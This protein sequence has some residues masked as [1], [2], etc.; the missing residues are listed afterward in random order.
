M[1]DDPRSY[2]YSAPRWIM[3]FGRWSRW[4]IIILALW[5][6]I[7][8][9]SYD[10]ERKQVDQEHNRISGYFWQ[11]RPVFCRTANLFHRYGWTVGVRVRAFRSSTSSE[12]V[13]RIRT[14]IRA[15]MLLMAS[16]WIHYIPSGGL[17]DTH[18]TWSLG[19]ED[20]IVPTCQRCL[21]YLRFGD[22][23]YPKVCIQA[24]YINQVI[25]QVICL[26]MAY[27]IS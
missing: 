26:R 18:S 15:T 12:T 7:R 20:R 3:D 1:I 19:F 13:F 22:P 14:T 4:L 5:L 21:T 23:S 9:S 16:Y 8:A 10:L 2:A 27:M 6:L 11:R 17:W 25:V 24:R